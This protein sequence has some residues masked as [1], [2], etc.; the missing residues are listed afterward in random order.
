[1]EA[2]LKNRDLGAGLDSK[3]VARRVYREAGRLSSPSWAII[4]QQSFKIVSQLNMP[5]T[6][7][8]EDMPVNPRSL[9]ELVDNL[10]NRK[11]FK[12]ADMDNH[13]SALAVR[14]C[15]LASRSSGISKTMKIALLLS[16]LSNLL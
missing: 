11:L 15:M 10:L 1:M 8:M 4:R 12:A 13:V 14:L 16:S 2:A 7:Y 6:Y 3:N 5:G 9:I